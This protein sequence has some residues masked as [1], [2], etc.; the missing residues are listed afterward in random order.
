MAKLEG[1]IS[2]AGLPAHRGLIV[3]LCFFRVGADST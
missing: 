2:I 3:S 1:T